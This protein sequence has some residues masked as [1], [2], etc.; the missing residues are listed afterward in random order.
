MYTAHLHLYYIPYSSMSL[1]LLSLLWWRVIGAMSNYEEFR[2]AFN[3]PETSVMNRGRSPVECGNES[4]DP[5]KNSI[6]AQP[7]P[8]YCVQFTG[9]YRETAVTNTD[10]CSTWPSFSHW[11]TLHSRELS[12][13]SAFYC[14]TSIIM[15]EWQTDHTNSLEAFLWFVTV[16]YS[17]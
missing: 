11:N 5:V 4:K 3:C 17:N 12:A 8:P 1:T 9:F 7:K 13:R 14:L 10:H 2:K 16:F 15:C 6:T